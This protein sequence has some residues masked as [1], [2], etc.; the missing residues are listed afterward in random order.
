MPFIRWKSRAWVDYLRASSIA[1]CKS[2][3]SNMVDEI[4]ATSKSPANGKLYIYL[5]GSSKSPRLSCLLLSP[6]SGF[7]FKMVLENFDLTRYCLPILCISFLVFLLSR[8]KQL[9]L[10]PSPPSDPVI[11]HARYI[12]PEHPWKTFAAWRKKFGEFSCPFVTLIYS[13]RLLTLSCNR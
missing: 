1:K 7:S 13:P 8:K 5:R 2:V 11:G 4:S 6:S 3:L 12:P 9:N 10:P